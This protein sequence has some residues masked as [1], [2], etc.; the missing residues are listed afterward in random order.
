VTAAFRRPAAFAFTT[1]VLLDALTTTIGILL[2]GIGGEAN[3]VATLIYQH[4]G[5]PSLWLV[6]ATEA[7]LFPWVLYELRQ[8]WCLR[9]L[10]GAMAV[11]VA[12]NAVSLVGLIH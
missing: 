1:L 11:V 12:I 7:V 10:T 3:P 6:K 5:L 9:F 2:V 8:A 4:G